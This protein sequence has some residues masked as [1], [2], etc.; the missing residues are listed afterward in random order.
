MPKEILNPSDQP[1]TDA[2]KHVTRDGQDSWKH[3]GWTDTGNH[4][5]A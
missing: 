5:Y 3:T 4:L 2:I 1:L